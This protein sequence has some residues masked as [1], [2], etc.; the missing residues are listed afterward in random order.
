[1]SLINESLSTDFKYNIF[2]N[3][4]PAT[5]QTVLTLDLPQV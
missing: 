2:R 4:G 1:M 5:I 3:Y